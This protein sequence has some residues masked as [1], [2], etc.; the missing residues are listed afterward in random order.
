MERQASVNELIDRDWWRAAGLEACLDRM[1]IMEQQRRKLA[2][3]VE[4]LTTAGVIEC[5]VRNPAVA[6]YMAH[7]E[8]RA[9]K[10]ESELAKLRA[11][12]R[13]THEQE[14]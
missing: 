13:A 12:P 1:V 2:H 8:C 9:E 7:W 6:E 4:M 3:E 14:R 5:A 11:A 10:A